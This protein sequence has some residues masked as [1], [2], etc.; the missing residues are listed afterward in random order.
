MRWP[1]ILLLLASAAQANPSIDPNLAQMPLGSGE[2]IAKP[3]QVILTQQWLYNQPVP[4]YQITIEHA[5]EHAEL[6]AAEAAVASVRPEFKN[7]TT[8]FA[9]HISH[10]VAGRDDTGTRTV[11]YIRR[12]IVAAWLITS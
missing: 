2:H 7:F 1:V 10:Y 8:D 12:S 3:F 4:V 9:Q 6:R 11:I 5:G